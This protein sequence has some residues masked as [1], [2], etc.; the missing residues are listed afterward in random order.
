MSQGMKCCFIYCCYTNLKEYF[1]TQIASYNTSYPI[2]NTEILEVAE[3][4]SY[5]VN[6]PFLHFILLLLIKIL[7]KS[8]GRL[9]L[10]YGFYNHL[11]EQIK[12]DKPVYQ[13]HVHYS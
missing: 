5:F 8:Y 4:P 2:N 9:C 7:Q 11:L 10:R 6:N 13:F 12:W 1:K 3:N